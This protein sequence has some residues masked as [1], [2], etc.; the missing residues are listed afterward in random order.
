ML[1]ARPA[2]QLRGA[3]LEAVRTRTTRKTTERAYLAV[4]REKL[5]AFEDSHERL[6]ANPLE[7][8]ILVA[9][10][11]AMV[12]LAALLNKAMDMS[13]KRDQRYIGPDREEDG[14]IDLV[15]AVRKSAA[16]RR[17]RQR[18]ELLLVTLYGIVDLIDDVPQVPHEPDQRG[19]IRPP[20][21]CI[22]A[23]CQPLTVGTTSLHDAR[24]VTCAKT[25]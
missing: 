6:G 10:Q 2:E 14:V 15:R 7:V 3:R 11:I 16:G 24:V 4:K 5:E 12:V 21:R 13:H 22:D 18:H 1:V 19:G 20:G 9:V 25:R 8:D 23:R 17:S